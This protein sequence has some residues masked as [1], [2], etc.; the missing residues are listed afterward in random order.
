M[1]RRAVEADIPRIVG[2]VER[3]AKA[4]DGPQRVCR[5]RAGETLCGLLTSPDGAAWV[6]EGGF[7]AGT[8]MQ[9][10]ISP[11]PVAIELGWF[12][13]DRSGLALLRE[14]ERWAESKGAVLIKL[15]CNG[16]VAQRMLERAGYRVAEIAMVK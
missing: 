16:G 9:T 13:E 4:V 7:I 2:M 6:S 5:V 1:I 14:F 3:L 15:S 12:A 10:I 11:D 8:I